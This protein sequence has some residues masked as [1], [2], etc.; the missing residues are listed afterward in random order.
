MPEHIADYQVF[1]TPCADFPKI[2][3]FFLRT[4]WK[5][6][7]LGAKLGCSGAVCRET[8]GGCFEQEGLRSLVGRDG[9]IL[10]GFVAGRASM[11]RCAGL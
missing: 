10:N 6:G 7:W 8:R 2:E 11:G 3:R 1:F 4:P 5:R 9:S